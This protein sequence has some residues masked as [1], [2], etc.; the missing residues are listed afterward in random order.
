MGVRFFKIAVIYFLIGLGVGLYMSSFQDLRFGSLHAHINLLGWVSMALFGVIY[1]LFPQ[2]G[3]HALAKWHF[4]LYNIGVPLM[5]IFLFLLI[6]TQNV[7]W[8][9]GI[10]PGAILVVLGA[11]C[12]LVN[13]FKHVRSSKAV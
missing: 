6:A 2:A 3:N 1:H 4:W 5:M 13:V 8:E 12:L 7:A 10:I 9:L 11:I